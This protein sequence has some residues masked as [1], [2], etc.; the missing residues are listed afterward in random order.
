MYSNP[1]SLNCHKGAKVVF[2]KL[3]GTARASRVCRT[4]S[5]S[6]MGHVLLVA[7]SNKNMQLNTIAWITN[8]R[9]NK[10]RGNDV[11]QMS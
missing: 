10:C 5:V 6:A 7:A 9:A 11:I 8:A 3:C 1:Y 2:H 4:E